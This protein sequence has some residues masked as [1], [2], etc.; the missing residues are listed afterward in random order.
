MMIYED[1]IIADYH[2]LYGDH[3]ASFVGRWSKPSMSK[4]R[5]GEALGMMFAQRH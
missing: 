5:F 2:A 3:S 4:C 1:L